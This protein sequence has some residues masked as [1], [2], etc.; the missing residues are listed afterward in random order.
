[1]KEKKDTNQLKQKERKTDSINK[2]CTLKL[3]CLLKTKRLRENRRSHIGC[4]IDSM[5]NINN[6]VTCIPSFMIINHSV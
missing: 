1:M 2:S 6:P 4:I 3:M 5:F